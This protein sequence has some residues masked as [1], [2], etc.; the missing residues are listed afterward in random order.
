MV[1]YNEEDGSLVNL[2]PV[3][4]NI[5]KYKVCISILHYHSNITTYRPLISW[6]HRVAFV[7]SPETGKSCGLMRRNPKRRGTSFCL[8]YKQTSWSSMKNL[9]REAS[10]KSIDA[11]WVQLCTAFPPTCCTGCTHC[12]SFRC[13]VKVYSHSDQQIGKELVR[14]CMIQTRLSHKNIV[15]CIG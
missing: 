11:L 5:N 1:S 14:E 10:H 4:S 9:D 3:S 13:A 15:R 6:R 7:P 8:I 2:V 12:L